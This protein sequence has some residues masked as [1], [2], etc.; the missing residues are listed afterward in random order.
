MASFRT[1]NARLGKK[2]N[3]PEE[4]RVGDVGTVE[5]TAP[6]Q[7]TAPTARTRTTTTTDR[8]VGVQQLI[9]G[10]VQRSTPAQRQVTPSIPRERPPGT[11]R[12][13]TPGGGSTHGTP[14][15]NYRPPAVDPNAPGVGSAEVRVIAP[16]PRQGDPN[17]PGTPGISEGG[18]TSAPPDRGY[19]Q[20]Q[21]PQISSAPNMNPWDRVGNWSQRY[22]KTAAL[23]QEVRYERDAN[24]NLRPVIYE[25][26]PGGIWRKAEVGQNERAYAALDAATQAVAGAPRNFQQWYAQ[27][28]P[29]FGAWQDIGE[30]VEK[31][32]EVIDNWNEL[33]SARDEAAAML[34]FENA[35]ELRQFMADERGRIQGIGGL[36][37]VEGLSDEERDLRNQEHMNRMR[38]YQQQSERDIDAIFGESGST[39]RA[40]MVADGY[41]RQIQNANLQH[42]TALMQEDF[43]R[44]MAN[45][46]WNKSRYDMLVRQGVSTQLAATQAIATERNAT[47]QQMAFQ[48]NTALAQNQQL[49]GLAQQDQDMLGA[50]V[51]Q[52]LAIADREA[53]LNQAVQQR[54]KAVYDQRLLPYKIQYEATV[55]LLDDYVGRLSLSIQK[56]GIDKASQNAIWQSL[57]QAIGGALGIAAGAFIPT[58]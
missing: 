20:P 3:N 18:D 1:I 41:R 47:I 2:R 6:Q 21:W 32:Q 54:M 28:D 12:V 43:T 17:T 16:P 30:L 9:G 8:G 33:G 14:D 40:W 22:A 7:P 34:G 49:Q 23:E 46:E 56:Y 51:S 35:D 19:R 48:V 29:Q 24:G 42:Q 11:V 50:T 53:G 26:Q 45:L 55:K 27:R 39:Q 5:P 15:P 38:M 44:R 10:A 52:Y 31:S 4:I 57:G 37:D 25:R 36:D 58:P 13:A